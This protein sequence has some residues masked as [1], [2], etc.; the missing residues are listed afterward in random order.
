M[1]RLARRR[2]RLEEALGQAV[3]NNELRLHYQ[4]VFD[5]TSGRVFG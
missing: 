3:V 2:L 4:P 1:T 5:V